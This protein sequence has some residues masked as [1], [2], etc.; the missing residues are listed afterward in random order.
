MTECLT[1]PTSIDLASG[2]AKPV[3]RCGHRH[4]CELHPRT[5]SEQR[6]ADFIRRRFQQAYGAR[7]TLQMPPLMALV[8]DHGTLLAAVGI[9]AAIRERLFLE[10]YLDQ[11]IEACLSNAGVEREFVV[12]IAHLAGVETGIS[13]PLFAALA[14]WLQQA[15]L[16][17]VVCTGT[18][19]LRNGFQ[20]LGIEVVDLGAADPGR[21][22]GAGQSWG[23]YYQCQPRVLA[24]NVRQSVESLRVGGLLRQVQHI[25]ASTD[26][27]VKASGLTGGGYGHTA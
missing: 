21:L 20:H 19:Q 11:P 10:D 3:V 15:G 9:R 14:V 27:V 5:A 26:G 17:W 4:L 22:A 18:A 1:M 16:K 24:I 7:P 6:A 13:R 25:D 8:S 23:S 2:E 12:E